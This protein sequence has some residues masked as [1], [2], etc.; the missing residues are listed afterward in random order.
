ML[1]SLEGNCDKKQIFKE[2]GVKLGERSPLKFY[3]EIEL[4][5]M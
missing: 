5:R 2:A 3:T 1:L 4:V